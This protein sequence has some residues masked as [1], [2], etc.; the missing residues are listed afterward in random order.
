MS[1]QLRLAVRSVFFIYFSVRLQSLGGGRPHVFVSLFSALWAGFGAE[2]PLLFIVAV[3]GIVKL[4]IFPKS[5]FPHFSCLSSFGFRPKGLSETGRGI[6]VV[7]AL[8]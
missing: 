8:G 7:R 5:I 3:K 6:A 1:V 2:V 4:S